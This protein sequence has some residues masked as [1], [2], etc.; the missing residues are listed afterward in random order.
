MSRE[1]RFCPGCGGPLKAREDGGR[2]RRAC[3]DPACGRVLYDNPTP[4]VAAIVER[5]GCV[6]LARAKNFPEGWFG[7]VTGFL[8]RGEDPAEGVLREVKE[9][10]GL[11]A[12]IVEL[13]GVY[14]FAPMNQVIIAYHVRA[15][16]EIVVGDE[17]AAVK[18]IPIAK[19][20]PWPGGTGDAVRDWLAKGRP[21]P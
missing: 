19:L 3:A 14:P 2:E 9:E 18:E 20:R 12:A 13:V 7:L 6:V 10:L 15:E 1:D 11:E 16:G 21:S 17:L 8:E 5:G 4:V